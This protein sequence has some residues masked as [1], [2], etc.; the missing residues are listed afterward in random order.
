M[1]AICFLL[2]I[3]SIV[4]EIHPSLAKKKKK[5]KRLN[6]A[7]P[8]EPPLCAG[9]TNKR[10][11][12]RL[13]HA[14]PHPSIRIQTNRIHPSIHPS[15]P[16]H[17]HRSVPTPT[18]GRRSSE[19]NPI[20][21]L[22]RRIRLSASARRDSTHPFIRSST[23]TPSVRPRRRRRPSV[24]LSVG[25]RINRHHHP[26]TRASSV[27]HKERKKDPSI[28]PSITR[29]VSAARHRPVC[30][31]NRPFIQSSIHP[32]IIV[33][34][35][36]VRIDRYIY[37][38]VR[39]FRSSSHP[40]SSSSASSRRSSR[41]RASVN[42]INPTRRRHFVFQPNRIESNRPIRRTPGC[43]FIIDAMRC[44]LVKKN[45]PVLSRE[46]PARLWWVTTSPSD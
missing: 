19:T 4:L 36:A 20:L 42:Q 1:Y 25:E 8:A 44:D 21:R 23:R 32:S 40:H 14:P 31:S 6:V 17:H 12:L 7:S 2:Q 28:H 18:I 33:P 37:I 46:R 38:R 5:K 43:L 13:V 27:T 35:R 34:S 29:F 41:T 15:I 26:R 16:R 39:T 9:W 22:A 24:R 10:A 30:R 11:S 45:S 3:S